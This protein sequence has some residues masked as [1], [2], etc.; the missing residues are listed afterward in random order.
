MILMTSTP[1]Q[2]APAFLIT[3]DT[4]GDNLWAKPRAV[5]TRNA[6][7]LS[8]F[9]S[10]CERYRLRP[11]Y[12]TNWEMARAPA[13][14][15]FAKDLLARSAGEIGMHLHAWNSPPLARLTADDD[16]HAPYLIEYPEPVIREKVNVMTQALEDTFGVKMLSHRAGRW[17]FNETYARILVEHGYRVDCSVT[18][19]V[20]WRFCKGDPSRDGGT[21]FTR[22]PESA[23]F[24]DLA[25][26][27]RPG[28]SPLL[29]LPVT[30]IR[31]RAYPRPIEALRSGLSGSF[32]G[33]AIM[34]RLF[35][36]YLWLMPTGENGPALLRVLDIAK[37]HQRPYVEMAIHSSELMPGGSPKLQSPDQIERLYA[38]LETLFSTA[39]QTFTGRTLAEYHERMS[40]R[41]LER[42]AP[43]SKNA[44]I[45]PANR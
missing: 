10:L 19:H 43:S 17:S 7:Y 6:E 4:E 24:L 26:I 42:D 28:D 23:Y 8:R 38:D 40:S 13:F 12:L 30:I 2:N 25:D 16:Q 9:Q 11:T 15:A 36:S 35:P 45:T 22:F 34:R 14:Q 39:A 32:Y 20:S 41:T 18:P 29:E 44:A 31:T 1:G 37:Q 5:T 21:D 3:V 33:S 27:R